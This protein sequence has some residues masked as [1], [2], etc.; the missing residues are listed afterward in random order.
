M[1]R[2][3]LPSFALLLG[4]AA[5]AAA[6]D[7]TRD[8]ERWSRTRAEVLEREGRFEDAIEE[9]TVVA[10]LSPDLVE[11][12]SR[13]AVLAV[14]MPV[15]RKQTLEPGSPAAEIAERLIQAGVARGGQGD[16][17][18]AYA[19]GRL[20]L[21]AGK[22]GSA[23]RLLC[24]AKQ[25]GFDPVR[26]RYW[27]YRAAVNRGAMLVES[28]RAQEAVDELEF[29]RRTQPNH[30]DERFLLIDLAAARSA[31]DEP[32]VAL[33][34]LDEILV[35][36]PGAADAHYLYAIILVRQGRLDEAEKRF[37]ET[38]RY[39]KGSFS[40]KEYRNAQLKLC[41]VQLKL[42]KLDDAEK[43]ANRY[44]ELAK[45]DPEG[46]F[47]LGRIRQSRGQ[48][49]E[50]AKLFRRV[51]RMS[52]RWLDTLINLKKVLHELGEDAEA[53]EIGRRIIEIE[54]KRAADLEG[55]APTMDAPQPKR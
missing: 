6:G 20:Q 51:A 25:W 21:A 54:K 4:F 19:A 33:K 9:W 24:D 36:T 14:E 16:P 7:T 45:D 22:W 30:P 27:H 1:L 10:R 55:K 40:D 8:W 52:P 47:M 53:E 26:V 44:L 29:L 15:Q 42:G 2:N 49:E 34:I 3:A 41:D 43:S 28:G 12:F 50:A 37:E 35:K 32:E 11:P 46:L 18:L 23:W 5:S 13:A 48:L 17:G 31:M 39:A 38:M